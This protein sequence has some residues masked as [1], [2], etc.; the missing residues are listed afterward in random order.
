MNL[1]FYIKNI[2]FVCFIPLILTSCSFLISDNQIQVEALGELQLIM[3]EEVEAFF[4]ITPQI[5]ENKDS[6]FWIDVNA[7]HQGDSLSFSDVRI[8]LHGEN[9]IKFPRKSIEL[10][11]NGKEYFFNNTNRTKEFFIIAMEEDSGYIHNF[12]GYS[13]LTELGLFFSHFEYIKVY[14]NDSY[15]GLYLLVEKSQDAIK[16]RLYPVAAVY[17]RDYNQDFWKRYLN[18]DYSSYDDYF[19]EMLSSL[20]K[21]TTEY[22]NDELLDSL[23]TI[24]K[25]DYYCRWLGVNK[26][27]RNGDYLDEVFFYVKPANNNKN[28]IFNITGWDYEDI[29]KPPHN[30]NGM[31][32]SLI[33]C[34]EEEFDVAIAEDSVL[35]AYYK[36]ILYD[37]LNNILTYSFIEDVKTELESTL[38]RQFDDS[39]TC[40]IMNNF[41]IDGMDAKTELLKL[42]D[43]RFDYI[44]FHR[45]S[46]LDVLN[47][48]N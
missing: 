22:N 35:Y 10:K 19:R 32:N 44:F 3:P 46:I 8:N 4:R 15:E 45:D 2:L 5:K 38:I 18:D 29:F 26:L 33:Y 27:L 11:F 40:H 41:F 37:E 13:L 1:N 16:D 34:S 47:E 31:E 36:T 43:G 9:S 25:M 42:I 21:F 39:T 24:L 20:Y 14:F 12:I 48:F 7:I 17:R 23:Q 6:L 30:G 28:F